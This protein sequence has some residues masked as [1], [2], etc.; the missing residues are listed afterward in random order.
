MIIMND[1]KVQVLFFFLFFSSFSY[2]FY[3]DLPSK[4]YTYPQQF[5]LILFPN[6]IEFPPFH[7]LF[8]HSHSTYSLFVLFSK[9]K[10]RTSLF[11]FQHNQHTKHQRYLNP[12]NQS[13]HYKKH[14]RLYTYLPIYD[15]NLVGDDDEWV[16]WTVNQNVNKK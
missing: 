14:N 12:S 13:L 9:N 4:L 2:P 6:N 3:I 5:F 11:S 7:S 1:K 10:K 15:N 8:S 16:E